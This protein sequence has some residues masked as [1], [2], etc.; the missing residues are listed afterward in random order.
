MQ[1][2][3]RQI[4]ADAKLEL[5]TPLGDRLMTNEFAD[6]MVAELRAKAPKFP[7][8]EILG[9][10]SGDTGTVAILMTGGSKVPKAVVKQ[11]IA[12]TLTDYPDLEIDNPVECPEELTLDFTIDVITTTRGGVHYSAADVVDE[13]N[14]SEFNRKL[15]SVLAKRRFDVQIES[16]AHAHSRSLSQLEFFLEWDGKGDVP[17]GPEGMCLVYTGSDLVQL[18][19]WRSGHEDLRLQDAVS[20][21][22]SED[23][24]RSIGRAVKHT[25]GEHRI[26]ADLDAMPLDVTDMFFV[27]AAPEGKDLAQYANTRVR[28]QDSLLGRELTE[29][30]IGTPEN[31]EAMV[32]CSLTKER[33]HN[34]WVVHG[35]SLPTTGGFKDTQ[36]IL[37]VLAEHQQGFLSWDRR[38]TLVTLR[39]LHRLKRISKNA[40]NQ[41]AQLLWSLLDLPVPAFQMVVKY[42]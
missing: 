33:E 25:T 21:G 3:H 29:Y 8:K 34:K 2:K 42:F 38:K 16:S 4:Y 18:I 10:G 35:L 9:V 17:E 31:S 39:A 15:T 11:A 7:V 41:F 30:N 24:L 19:D 32:M 28:V 1:G 40:T 36:Q 13:L 20:K 22:R 12:T 27:V 6:G 5:L 37:S 14:D 23:Y 26:S